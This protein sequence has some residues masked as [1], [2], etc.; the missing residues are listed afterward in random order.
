S[1]RTDSVAMHD[2]PWFT[3]AKEFEFDSSDILA[4][5]SLGCNRVLLLTID[6]GSG[7]GRCEWRIL[8]HPFDASELGRVDIVQGPEIPDDLM[9][10]DLCRI[11]D[12]VVAYGGSKLSDEGIVPFWFMAVYTISTG[13]WE[14]IPYTEG[15]CPVPRSAP[16]VCTLSDRMVVLGGERKESAE[17]RTPYSDTWEW[18]V[19]TREW[20]QCEDIPRA[21][22]GSVAGVNMDVIRVPVR[23]ASSG[24]VSVLYSGGRYHLDTDPWQSR[25][26]VETGSSV[27]DVPLYGQHR[28]V[29]TMNSSA[30]PEAVSDLEYW[31]V[32]SVSHDRMQCQPLFPPTPEQ[33]VAPLNG[34]FSCGVIP[35]M[36]NPTTLLIF[37]SEVIVRVT[38]DPFLV[39]PE[40]HTSMVGTRL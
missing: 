37:A 36:L 33:D 23:D 11:Q 16:Y 27:L 4:A 39:S 13:E 34:A 15:E 32:D 22:A 6:Y 18:S 17:G 21:L 38:I 20:T 5:A 19:D 24:D 35:V 30:E 14:T 2:H 31:I 25:L 29:I 12:V 10:V 40:F 9:V 1:G 8:T 7:I 3:D 28:L 26:G